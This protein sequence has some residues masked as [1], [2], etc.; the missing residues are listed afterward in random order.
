MTLRPSQPFEIRPNQTYFK[1]GIYN[2]FVDV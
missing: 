2:D 1:I